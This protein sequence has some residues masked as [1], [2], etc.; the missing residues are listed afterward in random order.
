MATITCNW[1]L[2]IA[3]I[4]IVMDHSLGTVLTGIAMVVHQFRNLHAIFDA[5]VAEHVIIHQH[6]LI[7][8]PPEIPLAFEISP[9]LADV[10]EMI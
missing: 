4:A 3:P 10:E 5:D 9:C 1:A 2:N 7:T 8:L 6:Q